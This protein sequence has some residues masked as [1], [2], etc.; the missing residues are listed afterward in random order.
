MDERTLGSRQ[1]YGGRRINLRIDKVVLPGGRET[2]REVVEHPDCVAIVAIDADD[3]VILVRQFRQAAAQELLE[4]P[5]GVIEP[6]E[7]PLHSAVRELE[8]ESGYSAGR[9]EQLGGFYSSPGYSTEYLYLFL[10]TELK[11]GP[12]RVQGDEISEVVTI[13]LK[14]VRNLITSGEIQDAKSIAGLFALSL[15]L[16]KSGV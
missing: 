6:G 8:E 4:V 7:E 9:I 15:H 5:A 2:T 3:N 10:A 1:I 13:P 14:Q 11:P 12:M 16:G